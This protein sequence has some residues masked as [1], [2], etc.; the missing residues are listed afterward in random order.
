MF[1]WSLWLSTGRNLLIFFPFFFF[2][3]SFNLNPGL[4]WDHCRVRGPQ[5][6]R[7]SAGSQGAA[8]T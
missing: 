2:F 1:P 7:N 8:P 6:Q 4:F 3:F 5:G